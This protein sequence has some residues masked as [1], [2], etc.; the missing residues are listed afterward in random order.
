VNALFDSAGL[1][2]YTAERNAAIAALNWGASRASVLQNMIEDAAVQ[3]ERVQPA[4]FD[5]VL[6]LLAARGR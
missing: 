5:A 2:P 1:V 3:T 6:W 4:L